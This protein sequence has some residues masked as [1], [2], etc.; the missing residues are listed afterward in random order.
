MWQLKFEPQ[1]KAQGLRS[2]ENFDCALNKFINF[3]SNEFE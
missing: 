2:N 3:C 1:L